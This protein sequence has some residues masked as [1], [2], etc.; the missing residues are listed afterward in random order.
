MLPLAIASFFVDGNSDRTRETLH[1]VLAIAEK[2]DDTAAQMAIVETLYLLHIR[3]FDLDLALLM[4]RRFGEIAAQRGGDMARRETEWT[5]TA[6]YHFIGDHAAVERHARHVLSAASI[7]TEPRSTLYGAH[8]HPLALCFLA[9][10]RWIQGFPSEAVRLADEAHRL[11]EETRQPV[12]FA[13]ILLWSIPLWI[14]VGDPDRAARETDR[15]RR[16]AEEHAWAPHLGA[17]CAAELELS[18]RARGADADTVPLLRGCITE[19]A[20]LRYHMMVGMLLGLLAETLAGA[21]RFAEARAAIAEALLRARRTNERVYLP[22]LLRLKACVL[23]AAGAPD[24]EV[25][26]AFRRALAVAE[27]QGARAWTLRIAISR[28]RRSRTIETR[29]ALAEVVAGFTEGF[30]TT[31]LLVARDLLG[32]PG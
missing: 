22:E 23:D 8:P 20:R 30:E 11:A 32:G 2:L 19:F 21:G 1:V 9:R 5:L 6:A 18:I 7:A 25:E 4:A 3:M 15:L 16:I 17:V 13:A 24:A 12:V 28:A 29:A 26:A 27:A 31:D 14:W 10:S